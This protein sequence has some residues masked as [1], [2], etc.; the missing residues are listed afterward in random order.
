MKLE[1]WE[2]SLFFKK[3]Y[4]FSPG[5]FAFICAIIAVWFKGHLGWADEGGELFF[6]IGSEL[7]GVCTGFVHIL[8][9]IFNW[10]D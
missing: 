8:E 5:T 9:C 2:G 10:D 4:S 6:Y 7:F 1:G 3:G